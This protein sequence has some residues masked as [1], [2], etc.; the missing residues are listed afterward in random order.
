YTPGKLCCRIVAALAD[1]PGVGAER[2]CPGRDVGRLPAGA[3]PGLCRS[4]GAGLQGLLEANDHIEQQVAERAEDEAGHRR[5][6]VPWT[7]NDGAVGCGRS[8]SADSWELPRCSPPPVGA[9]PLRS[10]P[11][12][13]G[14]PRS[15]TPRVTASWSSSSGRRAARRRI[16]EPVSKRPA[17]TV[18]TCL[19]TSTVVQTDTFSS[20]FS[21][22]ATHRRRSA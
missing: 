1:D 5:T 21:G 10:V 17:A 19:S 3:G 20:S 8:C 9:A 7:G 22:W 6:I 18:R 4:V 11:R 16:K 2:R 12:G 13:P 15:R 14:W